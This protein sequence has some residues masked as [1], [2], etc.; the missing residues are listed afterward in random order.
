MRRLAGLRGSLSDSLERGDSSL[1]C[2]AGAGDFVLQ[3]GGLRASFVELLP[4]RHEFPFEARDTRVCGVELSLGCVSLQRSSFQPGWVH[5]DAR[6]RREKDA[7]PSAPSPV[8]SVL[9]ATT[10]LRPRA[11]PVRQKSSTAR[12]R[13]RLRARRSAL[14]EWESRQ[15]PHPDCSRAAARIEAVVPPPV[16]SM[17]ET[18]SRSHIRS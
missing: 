18:R 10:R 11:R 2:A 7:L 17:G 13:R 1:G 8:K 4:C 6:Q 14:G 15:S 5:D 16:Q 12:T 3:F 9:S